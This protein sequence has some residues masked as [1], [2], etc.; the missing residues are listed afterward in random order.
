LTMTAAQT[1]SG[2]TALANGA[3]LALTGAGGALAGTSLAS[4][5]GST[6]TLGDATNGNNG[7]RINNAAALTLRGATLNLVSTN[8]AAGTNETYAGLTFDGGA[9]TINLTA[10]A[11]GSTQLIASG[12]LSRQ[13]QAMAGFYGPG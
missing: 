7:D 8:V 1:Y 4:A 13:N 10:N 5:S 3:I 6:L 2:P 12:G 9:S 11:S